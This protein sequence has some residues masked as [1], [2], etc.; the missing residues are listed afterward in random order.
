MTTFAAQR[1]SAEQIERI[2]QLS[3]VALNDAGAA[4]ARWG[5]PSTRE[6]ASALIRRLDGMRT[7]DD[8]ADIEI[9]EIPDHPQE[10]PMAEEARTKICGHC[11]IAKPLTEYHKNRVRSD[12]LNRECKQCVRDRRRSTGTDVTRRPRLDGPAAPTVTLTPS[13]EPDPPLSP[14]GNWRAVLE[15]PTLSRLIWIQEALGIPTLDETVEVCRLI[16][17]GPTP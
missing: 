2:R 3:A 15:D 7:H 14:N 16:T 6:E 4:F 12:G 5:Y 17:G 11:K 9:P 8:P 10:D 13:P 1:P